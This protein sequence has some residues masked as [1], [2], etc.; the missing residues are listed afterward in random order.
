M[1]SRPRIPRTGNTHKRRQSALAVYRAFAGGRANVDSASLTTL[2]PEFPPN[3]DAATLAMWRGRVDALAARARFTDARQFAALQPSSRIAQRLFWLLEQNRVETLLALSFP[4]A[5]QN[6]EVLAADAMVRARPGALMHTTAEGWVETLA[7]LCR[8]PLR[9]PLPVAARQ[10]WAGRWR[11]WMRPALSREIDSLSTQVSN[12][13]VY[14]QQALRV[15]AAAL[16]E[17]HPGEQPAERRASE[18]GLLS[19]EQAAKG[20]DGRHAR[21]HTVPTKVEP[22]GPEEPLGPEGLPIGAVQPPG[23]SY[24]VYTT[25]Y[26]QVVAPSDLRDA[27]SLRRHRA[28]LDRRLGPQ[29]NRIARCSRRLNRSLLSQQ[30][31]RWRFDLEEGILDASRLTRVVTNPHEPLAY[32]AEQEPRFPSTVVTLLLDNSGSMRGLRIATAAVCA[33]F[34]GRVLERCGVKT[35]ILGFTTRG[36]NGGRPRSKW[37]AAGRPE[38]PGRLTEIR[39]IVYKTARD[40]WRRSRQNLGLLVDETLLNENVDGEAV[41]WADA[42][43]RRRSEPRRILV[44]ISDGAPLDEATAEANGVDYLER[45]LREVVSWMQDQSAVELAAIGIG[46]NVSEFYLRAVTVS[47]TEGLGDALVEQLTDLFK[48]LPKAAARRP[49]LRRVR[50]IAVFANRE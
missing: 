37:L 38:S 26:D 42:R 49:A 20:T 4:G 34:L 48:V 46:H 33:E 50:P 13:T 2:L 41:L 43:L 47:E 14:A 17:I 27:E 1:A 8:V 7:L 24:R 30:M 15:L 32:K 23:S 29:L 12:Q 40:P 28:E 5:G 45:H 19:R 9:A 11:D 35:E 6:L 25:A 3:S 31:R 22:K 44:V 18:K 16:A 39:H 36:H 10:E 21:S